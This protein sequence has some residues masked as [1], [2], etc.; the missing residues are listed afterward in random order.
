M[1]IDEQNMTRWAFATL[2]TTLATNTT[3]AGATRHDFTAITVYAPETAASRFTIANGGRVLVKVTGYLSGAGATDLDAYRIGIKINAVAFDDVDVVVAVG[4][5]GNNW[6]F[7]MWRDVTAYFAANDPGTA[8]FDVEVGVAFATGIISSVTNVSAELFVT[9][10]V[11]AGAASTLC[12]TTVFPIQS[13]H[14]APTNDG[15]SFTEVGTTGGTADAPANQI[16]QLTDSGGAF[17]GVTG[18]TKRARYLLISAMT[19]KPS[20][21]QLVVRIAFDG[22]GTSV[23]VTVPLQI[24]ATSNRFVFAVDI[25]AL[26][27]SAAHSFEVGTQTLGSME[28]VGAIDVLSYEYTASS[29]TQFVSVQV[30]LVNIGATD[31]ALTGRLD[32]VGDA[33]RLTAVL[34]VPEVSPTIDQCGVMLYDGLAASGADTLIGATGQTV[35]TYDRGTSTARDAH[36]P[37]VHRTDHSSSDWA[38]VH[39]SNELSIVTYVSAVATSAPLCGYAMINYRCTKHADGGARHNRT[40]LAAQVVPYSEGISSV[41]TPD[42]PVLPAN[43]LISDVWGESHAFMNMN[44]QAIALSAER[45]AGEDSEGGWWR[46][47]R[48]HSDG[49]QELGS[50]VTV[51]PMGTWFRHRAGQ[52]DGGDIEAERSWSRWASS[53]G[54]TIGMQANL[55]CTYHT[56][57]FTVAGALRI[58]RVAAGNGEVLDVFAV[59]ADGRVERVTT[60]TTAGGAGAFTVTVPDDAREYFVSYEDGLTTGRSTVGVPTADTFNVY[61]FEGAAISLTAEPGLLRLLGGVV[62]LGEGEALDVDPPT[63]VVVSP[64]AAEAPGSSGA[65]PAT[66]AAAKD[67]PIVVTIKDALSAIA[68]VSL[69]IKFSDRVATEEVYAGTGGATFV[70]PY[71]SHSTVTGGGG[72][73]AGY[74][75]SI[76]RDDGWPRSTNGQPITVTVKKRAVDSEGNVLL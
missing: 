7:E 30:P 70:T 44:R 39:G 58:D 1:A 12:K 13:H 28:Q 17:D 54:V 9:Y 41:Q 29:T 2:L 59:D 18:F 32:A 35:R 27:D 37:I 3:L 72:P 5:S 60:A 57:T 65:F 26:S 51:H 66:H 49:A 43:Y 71:I 61:A 50:N 36:A 74:T 53:V 14:A 42:E 20:S 48:V 6:H 38:I 4:N 31:A 33:D 22:G 69:S 52:P 75:F 25:T 45:L 16:R 15:V 67:V 62:S 47:L 34:E 68:F 64:D 11:D 63:E 40:I 56:C 73:G 46:D 24:A 21:A 19:S 23:T 10:G 55:W 76:R 8:S